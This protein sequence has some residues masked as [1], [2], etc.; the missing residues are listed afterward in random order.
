MY[1]IY[2]LL[3]L[4]SAY[5][6]TT[7]TNP[8]LKNLLIDQVVLGTFAADVRALIRSREIARK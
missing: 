4:W 6:L 8:K 3:Y 7:N 2:T 1:R 5:L